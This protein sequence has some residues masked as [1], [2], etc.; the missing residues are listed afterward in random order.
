MFNSYCH[1]LNVSII[2]CIYRS[3]QN[4]HDFSYLYYVKLHI[5]INDLLFIT[6]YLYQLNLAYLN[7]LNLCLNVSSNFQNPLILSNNALHIHI[8]NLL[9]AEYPDTFILDPSIDYI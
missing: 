4:L 7:L 1:I 8:Y 6:N 5:F 9:N 3:L 2:I